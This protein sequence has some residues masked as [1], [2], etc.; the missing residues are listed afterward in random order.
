MPE[1]KNK[2]LKKNSCYSCGLYKNCITPKM[3]PTGKGEKKILVIAE[4]PGKMEDLHGTQLIGQAGQ[5]LRRYLKKY[6]VD[7]D[8]DC[9]K[10]NVIICR[11]ANNKTPTSKQIN[12]C[13]PNLIK[14]IEELKPE[15]ILLLGS[16]ALQGFSGLPQ[17]RRLI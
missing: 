15:K 1:L 2:K 5:T 16:I 8:R 11:P 4:A 14:T 9:W 13:R 10:T 6:G 7:L 12:C 17:K 3:Q